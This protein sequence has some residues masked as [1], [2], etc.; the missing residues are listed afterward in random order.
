[1]D[2]HDSAHRAQESELAALRARLS[3]LEQ[4]ER[5]LRAELRRVY[6]MHE[7]APY[8][9][10]VD[11]PVEQRRLYENRSLAGELGYA[12][13]DAA[14]SGLD[15]FVK[16]AHPDDQARAREQ[17]RRAQEGPA[18]DTAGLAYRLR[19]ADG[20]WGWF[21][22]RDIRL[23]A[24]AA[25]RARQVM[26]VVQDVTAQMESEAELRRQAE[27]G[28]VSKR[29]VENALDGITMTTLTGVVTYANLAFKAMSGFADGGVGRPLADFYAPE[30]FA[31]LA[32]VAMPALAKEG[33]WRGV[34]RI[35][36][37]DGSSWMGQLSAFALV[38]PTGE[39][40]G[41]AAFFRDITE[42]LRY[43]Q[44]T[45]AQVQLIQS[46]QA[47]LRELGTPLIPIAD[48]VIAMPLVGTIDRERAQQILETLLNAL[49]EKQAAVAILDI[50]GV[51]TVDAEVAAALVRVAQ[52]ARLLGA[53]VVL[54]G[55]RP[56]VAQ[57]L[58]E[59]GT[60]MRGLVTCGTL[61]S[62]IAYALSRKARP[63]PA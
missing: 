56:V 57:A 50:T 63:L 21:T 26:S 47:A 39:Q 62:G 28:A 18:S 25:G 1:M 32:N 43:E 59:L 5:E 30:D 15:A 10:S 40:T 4:I 27:D 20:S 7:A 8:L 3:E 52:A 49:G 61:Q 9:I 42:Q 19:R 58:V 13:D 46:Q 23:D 53:E 36:R 37:P 11:E 38:G 35:L 29:L 51:K 22:R 34:L 54:T 31:Q 60:E 2:C 17:Q 16:L 55:I 24:D 33:A 41:F 14:F 45:L 48:G 44:E 12:T 6:R